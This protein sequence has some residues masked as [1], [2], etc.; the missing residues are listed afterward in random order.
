MSHA[1]THCLAYSVDLNRPIAKQYLNDLFVTDDHEAHQIDVQ[2]FRGNTPVQLPSNAAVI[3]YFIRYSD[4]ATVTLSGKVNGNTASV[5]LNETCYALPGQ[6]AVVVKVT[7][8]TPVSAV[9]HAEGSM[10]ASKTDKVIDGGNTIPSLDELLAKIAD[11]EAAAS[12]GR[13]AAQEARDAGTQAVA[14]AQDAAGEALAAAE[15]VQS[16][17]EVKADAIMDESARAASHSLHAQDGPLAVTLYGQTTET[18]TGDKSPDNPY[19]ISGVDAAMVHVGSK[20]LFDVSRAVVH[21]SA[22]GLT[23][24]KNGDEITIKGT[25][26]TTNA[27]ASFAILHADEQK[28][29][30]AGKG[31]AVTPFAVSGATVKLYGLRSSNESTISA[32]VALTEGVA[33]ESKFRVM[34]SDGTHTAYEPYNANVIT[35]V[36][37]PDGA[38]LMGNGTVDDTIENDVLSGCDKYVILDGSSDEVWNKSGVFEY[39]FSGKNIPE[40]PVNGVYYSNLLPCIPDVNKW[41]ATSVTDGIYISDTP[42]FN[43]KA[44][45]FQIGNITSNFILC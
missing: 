2:L 34:V 18:G 1:A 7:E 32:T 31:Y 36:F 45:S 15:T 10:L 20:N 22:Y 5:L 23:I 37:L 8:G 40:K 12:D 44:K 25:A 6:F 30:L 38:P 26:T 9:F 35:P 3:G 43:I 39:T 24:T 16:I 17:Y 29:E 28:A 4:N 21:G 13:A 33:F 19:T 27:Y 41:N 42:S 14:I 11:M